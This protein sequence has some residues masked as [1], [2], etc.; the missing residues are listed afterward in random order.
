MAA[1][2]ELEAAEV[3]AAAAELEQEEE[4]GGS[5]QKLLGS[6][7][8]LLGRPSTDNRSTREAIESRTK[9]LVLELTL[10]LRRW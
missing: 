6:V 5:T 3:A 4:E 10:K 8:S 9:L 7:L 1:V 2:K